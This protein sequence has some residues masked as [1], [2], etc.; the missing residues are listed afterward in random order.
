[1]FC[2]ILPWF[3]VHSLSFYSL[4][5]TEV[6]TVLLRLVLE[7]RFITEIVCKSATFASSSSISKSA[8][9]RQIIQ[10]RQI[11][12]SAAMATEGTPFASFLLFSIGF[13]PF[14]YILAPKL[15]RSCG[16]WLQILLAASHEQ[17]VIWARVLKKGF[18]YFTHFIVSLTLCTGHDYHLVGLSPPS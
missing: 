8:Q 13:W 17:L 9:G 11:F 2:T 12:S 4:L 14:S 7:N 16:Y 10:W 3:P 1:M 18:I 15:Y 6:E 5:P